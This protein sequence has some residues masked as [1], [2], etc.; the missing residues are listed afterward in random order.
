ME[1]MGNYNNNIKI[2]I[3]TIANFYIQLTLKDCANLLT[4]NN[5]YTFISY[6]I[7]VS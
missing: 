1:N 5:T 2:S 6:L 7:S 4:H 3:I